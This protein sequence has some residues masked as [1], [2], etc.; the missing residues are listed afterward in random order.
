MASNIVTKEPHGFLKFFNLL[1]SNR[2]ALKKL[3]DLRFDVYN[4]KTQDE[5]VDAVKKATNGEKIAFN[6]MAS[7]AALGLVLAA[8]GIGQIDPANSPYPELIK[9]LSGIGPGLTLA[10]ALPPVIALI[11]RSGFKSTINKEIHHKDTFIDN[12]LVS[13]EIANTHEESKAYQ[14]QFK[15]FCRCNMPTMRYVEE[16][17]L[18]EWTF[19]NDYVRPYE[20]VKSRCVEETTRRDK[21]GKTKKV[22]TDYFRYSV[23]V[24]L[25]LDISHFTILENMPIMNVRP[26]IPNQ[27]KRHGEEEHKGAMGNIQLDKAF[28]VF[29]KKED[30]EDWYRF[31]NPSIKKHIMDLHKHFGLMVIESIGNKICISF[32]DKDVMVANSEYTINNPAKLIEELEGQKQLPKLDAIMGLF[33]TIIKFNDSNF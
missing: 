32:N 31:M 9:L 11:S 4:A 18:G 7:F 25:G 13:K 12:G 33:N 28:K 22:R 8:A 27:L 26:H 30:A 2:L 14:N 19:E 21:D 24:D 17:G 16:V 3:A 5:L 1:P 10:M 23:I 20:L 6:N 29:F 15:D